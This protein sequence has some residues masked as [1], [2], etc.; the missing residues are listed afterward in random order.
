MEFPVSLSPAHMCPLSK[1]K[2]KKYFFKYEEF[3][4]GSRRTLNQAWEHSKHKALGYTHDASPT[5]RYSED[6]LK[7]KGNLLKSG[8][9]KV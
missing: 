9:Y 3:Y 5:Q 8:I 7:I 6:I 4:D 1:M 2:F